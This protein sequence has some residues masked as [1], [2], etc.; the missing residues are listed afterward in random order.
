MTWP[1]IRE[2][3]ED[4]SLKASVAD[5]VEAL[6]QARQERDQA[7]AE[8]RKKDTRIASLWAHLMRARAMLARPRRKRQMKDSRQLA[9]PI[10]DG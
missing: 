10:N 8:I 7:R 3:R 5:L 6:N 9:L 2:D 4:T 1:Q